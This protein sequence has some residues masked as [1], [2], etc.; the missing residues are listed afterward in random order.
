MWFKNLSLY[1]LSSPFTLTMDELGEKLA[2]KVFHPAGKHDLSSVGWSEPLGRNGQE[3]FHSANGFIMLCLRTEQKILPAAAVKELVDVR[4]EE[5]EE[6]EARKVRG[7]ER[8]ALKEQ[9]L[10]EM[11]PRA[12]SKSSRTFAYIDP[13]EGWLIVDAASDK[14]AEELIGLLRKSLGS[15]PAARINMINAPS[16]IMT[17]WLERE[18]LPDYLELNDECELRDSLEDGG[19]VK[20]RKQSLLSEEVKIHLN[21]GKVVARLALIFD[22]RISFVL[23]ENITIKKVRFLDVIQEEAMDVVTETAA[24]RFDSDFAIMTLELKRFLPVLFKA[25]GGLVELDAQ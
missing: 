10:M 18:E 2:E 21:A 15:F 17:Q 23:D 4:A 13:K 1:R 5:I 8:A 6:K 7:K 22:E 3:L 11:V 12:F 25:L 20:I 9:V 14:K 16:A 19:I 24:E